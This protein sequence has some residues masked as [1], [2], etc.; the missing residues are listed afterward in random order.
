MTPGAAAASGENSSRSTSTAEISR[1][2]RS[3]IGGSGMP[4]G[5]CSPSNQPAPRPSTN[6]PPVAWSR[7]V[8]AF[9]SS[10]GWRNVFDST[11]WPTRTPGTWW[12]SVARSVSASRDGPG[13]SASRSVRWSFIQAPSQPPSSPGK[14][15]GG[16]ERR[17]VHV[18]RRGLERD[19]ERH[20][21]GLLADVPGA[22]RQGPAE[23]AP[24]VIAPSDADETSAAYFA[25]TPVV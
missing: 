9:A 19:P 23:R 12:T 20:L 14:R 8:A 1:S 24:L 11:P 21:R 16:V 7:T 2:I 3:P 6:R 22:G 15:P 17:P 13:L 4:K 10:T 25:M 18:L 5:T